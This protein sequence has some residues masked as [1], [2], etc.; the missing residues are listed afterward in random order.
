MMSSYCNNPY[1]YAVHNRPGRSMTNNEMSIAD[2][3]NVTVSWDPSAED[4]SYRVTVVSALTSGESM[5][6]TMSTSLQLTLEYSINYTVQV[7]SFNCVGNSSVATL[8]IATGI[9]KLWSHLDYCYFINFSTGCPMLTSSDTVVIDSYRSREEGSKV[10]FSCRE[11][12]MPSVEMMSTC[13]SG[14][15]LPLDPW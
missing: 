14:R 1:T 5:F 6:V 2:G 4:I 11:A 10:T 15:W 13:S 7:V 9:L 12:L 3:V 8:N